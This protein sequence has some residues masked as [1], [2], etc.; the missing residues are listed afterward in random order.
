MNIKS[1]SVLK[2]YR[3]SGSMQ[4]VPHIILVFIEP[5]LLTIVILYI[6]SIDN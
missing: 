5:I 1:F 3:K 2:F 4:Y 6:T